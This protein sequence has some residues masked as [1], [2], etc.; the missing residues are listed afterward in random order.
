MT[1]I[2]VYS[3]SSQN[4]DGTA[5]GTSSNPPK[6]G[7]MIKI[8]KFIAVLGMIA[9]CWGVPFTGMSL[10]QS[11]SDIEHIKNFYVRYMEA[12]EESDREM[13]NTLKHN[14]LTQEM[15][16]KMGRLIDATGFDP[17]LRAQDVS[18]FGIQ[19]LQCRH[20]EDDWYMV[21]Y[22][23]DEMDSVGIHIPLRIVKDAE[24]QSRIGYVT[25]ASE[26]QGYGN[27]IFDIS[28]VVIEGD[29]DACTFIETFF[30][31]YVYPYVRMLPSLDQDLERLRQ[32]YFTPDM[33]KKYVTISQMFLEDASPIDPLI[34]KADFDAFW[35]SSIM[36]A[37][38]EDNIFKIW[39]NT[40]YGVT[41]VK[42][43]VTRQNGEYRI[44]ELNLDWSLYSF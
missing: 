6:R 33:Q 14:F 15:Q 44:S 37:P 4:S 41:Y 42:L 36:V 22:H 16:A 7:Y 1:K 39:Y 29:K 5:K 40:G 26:R 21:S 24:G 20:L 13:I 31:A 19:T 8:N 3:V 9:I 23:R 17:L 35:Y 12:I 11:V 2:E 38:I 10:A 27:Q 32:T 43:T 18:P 25:P 34:G 30:K 28:E